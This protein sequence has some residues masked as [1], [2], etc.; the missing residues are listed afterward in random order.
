MKI[1]DD[2]LQKI[3]DTSIVTVA[4][5]LGMKLYGMGDENRKACCPYHEDQHPSLHFS[6]KRGCF[7]CFVCGAKGDAIKLVQDQENLTFT[8][9]CEWIIKECNIIVTDDAPAPKS[10]SQRSAAEGKAKS[11]Q[12]VVSLDTTL[13]TRSLSLDS[14][15]CKSAVSAGYLTDSQLRHAADRYRLG[16]SKEGG[17]I[18]WEIDDQQRVHT[19]KIMYYQPDCHR[20]KAHNPTW[21]HSLMKDKLP[22]NYELQH[23]LFGLHL[24]SSHP[25][26]LMG[27]GY[28][29]VRATGG[30]VKPS[31]IGEGLDGVDA[32]FSSFLRAEEKNRSGNKGVAIVE[33][34]KTAII[35]SEKFPDFIWLSCGG[36]QM[37]KPELLAP[38]VNHKVVIFPD[39]DETGEA[40]KQWLTV[41][42][43]AQR[44]YVFK[45]PLRIS[46]LLENHASQEQKQQKIDLVDYIFNTV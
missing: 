38:L 28:L 4:D 35:L 17:V 14:Q 23:C 41:L 15:F 36:L 19:G 27:R 31:N 3:H 6:T 12:S 37:F 39:T 33:S 7:K 13:V 21:V 24:L 40:Y 43:Q 20:D 46:R 1:S 29:N 18:F 10:V 45:Y 34:E 42:Q 26:P 30:A 25:D 32:S 11:A 22:A 16:C 9:A 5:K 8:E 44:Q 2:T